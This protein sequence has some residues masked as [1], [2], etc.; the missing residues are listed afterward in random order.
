MTALTKHDKKKTGR[1]ELW[2]AFDRVF[3]DWT[4]LLPFRRDWEGEQV[5]RV[6]EFREDGTLVIR[7]EMPGVDPEKDVELTVVD[8]ML[9]ISA[10]RREEQTETE[11]G[12]VR[13][14][15]RFGSFRRTLPV[16]SGVTEADVTATYKD[17][18]LEVRVPAPM[19]AV[20]AP[21]KIPITK[22]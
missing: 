9:H 10:E 6:D 14:E 20:A 1:T 21:A 19:A 5:I 7:A 8:G 12:F 3:D 13:R 2:D 22:A 16:P 4:K 15:L 11:R 18:I 17:G